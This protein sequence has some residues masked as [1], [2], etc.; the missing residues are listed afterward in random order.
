MIRRPPRSTLLPYTTLFRS[1]CIDG[2]EVGGAKGS[3][4][5]GVEGSDLCIGE[6]GE[7]GCGDG[8][9]IR[10]GYA[11]GLSGDA[12]FCLGM[13]EGRQGGGVERTELGVCEGPQLGTV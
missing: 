1:G 6:L 7:V 9:D 13:G 2:G 11:H 12:V 3:E 8:L 4:L 5:S 10:L